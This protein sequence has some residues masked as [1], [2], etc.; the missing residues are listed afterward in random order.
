LSGMARRNPTT[1]IAC[2]ARATTGQTAVLPS[3]IV[4]SRRLTRSPRRSGQAVRPER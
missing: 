4:N 1:G 2:C 3:P